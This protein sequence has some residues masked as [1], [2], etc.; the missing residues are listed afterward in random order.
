M[1]RYLYQKPVIEQLHLLVNFVELRPLRFVSRLFFNRIASERAVCIA[2]HAKQLSPAEACK[3]GL[4]DVVVYFHEHRRFNVRSDIYMYTAACNG[5]LSIVQWLH[6]NQFPCSNTAAFSAAQNGHLDVLQYLDVSHAIVSL[7][8]QGVLNWAA[9]GG[10]LAS[11][12]WLCNRFLEVPPINEISYVE[13]MNRAAT[14]GSSPEHLQVVR[15]LHEIIREREPAYSALV[16]DQ[17]LHHAQSRIHDN[18]SDKLQ[19]DKLFD[20]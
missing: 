8:P 3:L 13:A 2:E 18:E 19:I 14:E 11:V 1:I 7:F 6:V 5:H 10:S 20:D 17:L 12:Q 15:L 9:R 4:F 16:A